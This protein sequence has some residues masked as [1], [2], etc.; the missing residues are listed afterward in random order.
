ML[1]TLVW[2]RWE[3]GFGDLANKVKQNR[4]S[5]QKLTA[6]TIEYGATDEATWIPKGCRYL[7]QLL[8]KEGIPSQT[9][10]F[11]GGHQDKLG[12]RLGQFMLP[13]FSQYLL[14]QK[15]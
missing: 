9:V 13:F 3:S 6:L 11:V 8:T 5:L 7:S 4:E 12:E 2:Q 15:P 14:F 10:A 1:D